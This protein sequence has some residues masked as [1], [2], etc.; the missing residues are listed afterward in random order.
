MLSQEA[1]LRIRKKLK[2]NE[3]VN[4]GWGAGDLDLSV[5]LKTVGAVL[6]D[7]RDG[8]K[9]ER[10]HPTPPEY[11]FYGPL[12]NAATMFP[13]LI[14][15]EC[16]SENWISFHDKNTSTFYDLINKVDSFLKS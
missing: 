16:C 3:C 7:T 15:K 2:G 5:C 6:I 8:K 14:G 4:R 1:Y 12:N 9:R 11:H 10:F 13:V